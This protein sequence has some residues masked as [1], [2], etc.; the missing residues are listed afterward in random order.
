MSRS[1][2]HCRWLTKQR[3]DQ[4]GRGRCQCCRISCRGSGRAP[5]DEKFWLIESSH[6][7][8]RLSLTAEQRNSRSR[9]YASASCSVLKSRGS[10]IHSPESSITNS[11]FQ[12]MPT[13]LASCHAIRA[14]HQR[15]RADAGLYLKRAYLWRCY[16]MRINAVVVVE[17]QNSRGFLGL[18][19]R[20]RIF[21]KSRARSAQHGLRFSAVGSEFG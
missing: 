2:S 21:S 16:I 4:V 6:L 5:V 1:D 10:P 7:N 13:S 19:H 8:K 20:T 12:D 9:A 18:I 17:L 15:L 14:N 11:T 3:S